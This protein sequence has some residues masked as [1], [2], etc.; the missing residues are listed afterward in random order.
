M[1]FKLRAIESKDLKKVHKLFNNPFNM[2]FW[3]A[4]PYLP[5]EK[6]Q[7]KF[8]HD[9][10][11]NSSRSFAIT[12]DEK[13]AGIIELVDIDL[14]SQNAEIQIIIDSEF[15]GLKLAQKAFKACMEYGFNTLNLHKIYLN[16]DVENAPAVNVYKK[17]GFNIEGTLKDQYFADGDFR[18]CY[19]MG[20]L[21]NNFNK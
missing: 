6:L 13:F 19:F 2:K 7:A 10:D 21:K 20:I 15:R 18:D 17:M 11:D 3:F 9:L 12:H 1:S 4:E 8:N 16:V 14:I 5:M